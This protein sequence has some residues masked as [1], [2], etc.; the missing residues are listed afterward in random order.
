MKFTPTMH[1]QPMH[2]VITDQEHIKR[3]VKATKMALALWDIDQ[4]L[5]SQAK[6]HDN[7]QAAELREKMR[8]I[9][10][11]YGIDLDDLIS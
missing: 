1:E 4:M 11:G 8:E 5:R 6:Y 9:M 2:L 7:H 10:E 3:A